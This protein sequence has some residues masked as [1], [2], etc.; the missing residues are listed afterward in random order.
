M[1]KVTLP[2]GSV[3]VGPKA[4]EYLKA[5]AKAQKA[6][7]ED[8]K[9][10]VVEA[11]KAGD[12]DAAAA[13]VAVLE[14]SKPCHLSNA[15]AFQAETMKVLETTHRH[16]HHF[17]HVMRA[18]WTGDEK[19]IRSYLSCNLAYD[20]K[21]APSEKDIHLF[22]GNATYVC[23]NAGVNT[24]ESNVILEVHPSLLKKSGKMA[25]DIPEGALVAVRHERNSAQR[26]ATSHSY[27]KCKV[28]REVNINHSYIV[29]VIPRE[30]EAEFLA[31]NIDE[32]RLRK[33]RYD[34]D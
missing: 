17:Y 25:I 16:D 10:K 2:D 28:I 6:A 12:E 31:H 15:D 23:W 9:K 27:A 20:P 13:A 11:K 24:C 1:P 33:G 29:A 8:A 18:D 19:Q 4:D 5:Q 22:A 32:T 34:T 30:R 3:L 21:D 26:L 7:K 14:A